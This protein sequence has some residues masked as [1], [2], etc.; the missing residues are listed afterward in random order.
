MWRD[1]QPTWTSPGG[2]VI[3]LGDA[4]HTFLPSSGN[5][6]TQAIEDAVSLAACLDVAGKDNITQ[7]TRVHNLL[8]F[9]RVS[10]L[11]ALGVVNQQKVNTRFD[12]KSGDNKKVRH[13]LGRWIVEHDPEQYAYE[14]YQ[15]ALKHLMEG[16]PFQN[17]NTPPGHVYRPWKIDSLLAAQERGEQTVLDGDWD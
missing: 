16:A 9:E 17:T 11:Q 6:G 2:Q 7:A 14:N 15:Q 5:G 8:R 3:Q 12:D 1:P 4:A 10:C 13:H